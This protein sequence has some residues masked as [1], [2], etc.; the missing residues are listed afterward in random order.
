[1]AHCGPDLADIDVLRAVSL[2]SPR[3]VAITGVGLDERLASRDEAP[4]CGVAGAASFRATPLPSNGPPAEG[5]G[6]YRTRVPRRLAGPATR[7]LV[8]AAAQAMRHAGLERESP[9]AEDFGVVVSHSPELSLEELVPALRAAL[10]EQGAYDAVRFGDVALREIMPL[11]Y[12]R[13]HPVAGAALLSMQYQAFAL[14]RV[15]GGEGAGGFEA[16]GEGLMSIRRGEAG[17]VLCGGAAAGTSKWRSFLYAA[18]DLAGTGDGEDATAP[19][20]RRQLAEGAGA[21]V[22]E[23]LGRARE[24]SA[25]VLAEVR[26]YASRCV[27]PGSNPSAF[28]L[29]MEGAL[30]DA[31]LRAADVDCLF[32]NSGFAPREWQEEQRALDQVFGPH[33]R[34]P[35]VHAL[36]PILGDL[37][38]AA[39]LVDVVAAVGVLR[40]G[41]GRRAAILSGADGEGRA[42]SLVL[43]RSLA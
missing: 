38:A 1:M 39:G 29:A 43:A 5:D 41:A 28:Q 33:R 11:W 20:S 8:E 13:G 40:A 36:K 26:G 14:N 18:L 9:P 10:D 19:V 37:T 21:V 24:R 23:E 7:R 32:M 15:V 12:I 31:G 22:L 16:I 4:W 6:P 25:T 30:L 42:A 34:P 2:H 3:R 35:I 27:E 17:V